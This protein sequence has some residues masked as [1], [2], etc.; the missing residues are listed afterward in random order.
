M[1]QAP[2]EKMSFEQSLAEMESIVRA[3]ESGKAPLEDSI[4]AYERGMAL[5]AH[6]EKKLKEAQS[7]IEKITLKDDGSVTLSPANLDD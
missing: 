4:H 2:V 7:R 5:R 6:C 1:P 3:L